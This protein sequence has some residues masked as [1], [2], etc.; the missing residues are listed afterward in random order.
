MKSIPTR[1]FTFAKIAAAIVVLTQG[2]SA[3]AGDAEIEALKESIKVLQQ[4]I[5]VLEQKQP[6][7]TQAGAATPAN[8]G[9]STAA[10]AKSVK[11]YGVL[12]SGV[13]YLSNVGSNHSSLTR[14]PSTTGSV[15]TRVG[16]DL[17]HEVIPGVKG[18]ANAEMGVLLDTGSSGQ[19]SRLFGRQ[20]YV[21]I[22]TAYGRLTF[23]RQYSMLFYGLLGSDIIGPNIFGLSSL[24]NYIPN[25]RSDNTVV[26][27]GKFGNFSLGATYSFGRDTANTVPQS[28]SCSGE[29]AG[30]SKCQ[31]WSAMV[32]YDAPRFGIATAIDKQSGGTGATASYF[33]GVTPVSL[34]ASSDS[35]TRVTVNGYGKLGLFKLG[36]GW[37]NRKV[38]NQSTSIRQDTT[39]I[40]GE[41][42]ITAQLTVDGGLFH[43]SNNDQHTKANLYVLR[44]VYNFDQQLASYVSIGHINNDDK[45]AYSLSG[46]GAG[47]APAVG[48]DQNGVMMG[49]RYKF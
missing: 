8:A 29:V 7:T 46:G 21:G 35:D 34:A 15:P 30:S 10:I 19:G 9:G 6:A 28:G 20:A 40:Q 11:I 45:S 3:V 12:D 26:W 43:V 13:E 42:P 16:I 14:I 41:Y 2:T 4:K 36:V 32:K 24:D 18:I 44:G 33:N 49:V 31:M 17:Q 5:S 48:Y 1:S 38:D 25:A 47:A 39:W 22:E 27:Q 23:G 37:L